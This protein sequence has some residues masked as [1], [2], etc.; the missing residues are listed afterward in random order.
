MIKNSTAEPIRIADVIGGH[1]HP[2]VCVTRSGATLVVYN[3]EGSGGKELL[4]SRSSD[5]GATWSNPVPIPVIRDCSIYPGSLTT[6]SDGRILLNWSC[7]CKAAER[8]WREPQFSISTN[9]GET[10][11]TPQ[12]YPITDHT[13]YT[14]MRHAVA[15]WSTDE[16][17][18]PFY[19]RTVLYNMQTE[20]VTPFGDGC[21][22]G[23]API[24]RTSKGTLISGAP[25]AN[26]PVPVGVPG[27]MVSGLRSTDDGS[28]WGALGVFPHFGVAGY[29]LTVL[30]NGWIVLTYIVYG[31]GVDGEF[32]YE[33]VLSRDDGKTW[34]F[35]DA[36]EVYNPGRRIAGRGWPR[37]VQIDAETLGT[38]F[39]DLD[40]DQ[41]GGAGVFIVW[42]PLA[43]LEKDYQ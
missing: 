22:H 11:S 17:V 36:F 14:C 8:L 27:N 21:N 32:S 3:K 16:W 5:A 43:R 38:V 35:D 37:T 18:C 31:V 33:L 42:T 9:E 12:D 29:D 41:P 23:M 6:L 24:V 39:Y 7:Y 19:D 1:V 40:P 2:A 28:T 34:N 4:L 25:Q 13:N 26:A 15:E 10:W 20:S 30:I